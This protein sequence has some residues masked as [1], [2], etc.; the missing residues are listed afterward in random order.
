MWRRDSWLIG[1]VVLFAGLLGMIAPGIAISE[2]AQASPDDKIGE[3]LGKPILRRELGEKDKVDQQLRVLF[4]M[5]VLNKYKKAHQQEIEPTADEI[6]AATLVFNQQFKEQAEKSE[7][8]L[9]AQIKEIDDQLNQQDLSKDKRLKLQKNKKSLEQVLE[10]NKKVPGRPFAVFMLTS[11]KF[12]KHLYDT[13]GGGRLLWQQGGT[14]AFDAMHKWLEA[15]EKAGDF[16]FTDKALR[17]QFYAYWTTHNHGAFL[18][19]DPD[20]IKKEFL[21]PAWALKSPAKK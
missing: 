4:L 2:Q 14:E 7:P 5:P 8:E 13:Y 18:V 16:K 3:V 15:R 12:Q 11:W 21:E 9:R 20:R 17:A 10:L 1:G 6:S 19:A